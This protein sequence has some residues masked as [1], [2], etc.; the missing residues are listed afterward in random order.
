MPFEDWYT[1]RCAVQNNLEL[2]PYLTA[3]S[4]AAPRNF[5]PQWEA[6]SAMPFLGSQH[7]KIAHRQ[8]LRGPDPLLSK[9]TNLKSVTALQPPE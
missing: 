5:L 9:V 8:V 2:R 3:H 6:A 7:P 1:L 4:T